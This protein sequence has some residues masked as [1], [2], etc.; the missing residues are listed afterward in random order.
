MSRAYKAL[1]TTEQLWE[2]FDYKPLTGELVR[3]RRGGKKVSTCVGAAGYKT[4]RVNDED[5]GQHR[6][7]WAW[8]T[9]NRVFDEIDH[10]DGVGSN[11]RI[12]N[13]REA[14]RPQN[15]SNQRRKK[16]YHYMK[17]RSK[18][19]HA[20]IMVNYKSKSLGYYRTEAEAA[21]AYKKASLE[22]HGAFSPYSDE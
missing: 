1:P 21:A 12:N 18:P 15:A 7:I 13:L 6:V 3:K 14:T 8:L 10:R 16:G 2:Q 17:N 19:W 20:Q 5:F 4:V 22:L 11:N 9:G